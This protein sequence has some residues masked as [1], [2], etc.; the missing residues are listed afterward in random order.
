MSVEM[1]TPDW[2]STYSTP[3]PPGP[4]PQYP[5]FEDIGHGA[6]RSADGQE[7]PFYTNEASS[8]QPMGEYDCA[9]NCSAL[10]A[11]G[12]FSWC[13][14]SKP[15]CAGACHLYVSEKTASPPAAGWHYVSSPGNPGHVSRHTDESWWRCYSRKATIEQTT[16]VSAQYDPTPTNVSS[17]MFGHEFVEAPAIFKREGIYYALF[18]KCC[19]FCGHGSGSGVYTAAHP[20][21]PWTY[22]EQIAC[23]VP[24]KPGCGCGMIDPDHSLQCAPLYGQSVT[25]AQQNFVMPVHTT[26]GVMYI[27]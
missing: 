19:C 18:G 27:W 5:G 3:A 24:P 20:L 15:E 23:K 9:S 6:C 14:P 7:P 26:S 17:G 21:G 22:H 1:L 13:S 16:S 10:S 12:G 4:D 25:K 11:C 8:L 2:L